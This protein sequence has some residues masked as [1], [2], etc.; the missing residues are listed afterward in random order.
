MILGKNQ[1]K[2][3]NCKFD[4]EPWKSRFK[5]MSVLFLVPGFEIKVRYKSKINIDT[6][7]I[8]PLGAGILAT[9]L[10]MAGCNLKLLDL[11]VEKLTHEDILKI[12]GEFQPRFIG[13]SCWSPTALAAFALGLELFFI[14]LF[15]NLIAL[16]VVQ[17]YR[18]K[19]E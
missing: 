5:G 9:I 8:Q 19:Y 15:L 6:G 4:I 14:T 10:K 1:T 13:I 17:K 3:S 16:R 11:P 18:E 7:H 2:D 12:V